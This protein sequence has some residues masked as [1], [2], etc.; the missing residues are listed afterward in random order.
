MQQGGDPSP[1]D[2]ILATRFAAMAIDYL[3]QQIGKEEYVSTCVGQIGGKIHFTDLLDVPRLLDMVHARPKIQ[4]WMAL[5][6]LA[7]IMAQP[8]P[9]WDAAKAKKESV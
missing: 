4:W 2:R 7:R 5:R 3:D 8:E 6:D 1:F 9:R